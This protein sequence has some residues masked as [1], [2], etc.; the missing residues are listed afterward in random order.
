MTHRLV[1]WNYLRSEMLHRWRRTAL[2]IGGVALAATLVVMLDVLGRAF[3]D[4][5]TVPFRNLGA[6]LIVQRSATQS[7]VPKQMGIMLPFSAQPITSEELVRLAAEPGVAQAAGFVLLWNL[8]SGSFF[9][10]SGI[11][12]DANAPA[13]GPGRAREWLFKGRLP[14]AGER[15]IA[16]ERHYGAFYRL[17]PGNSI[18]IAGNAFKIVGVVETK[19]GSQIVAS[20][21]YMEIG[22]ARELA[23]LPPGLVKQVFLKVA[24]M[25]QTESIKQRIAK[26][27]PRASVASPGTMLQLF[28]GVSQTIGKFRTVGVAAG[29]AAALALSAMLILGALTERRRE[30]AVLRVIGWESSQVRRQIA[31]EMAVQGLLAG[32]LAIGLVAI[33]DNL[34]AHITIAMPASLPGENPADFAASG[35]HAANSALALPVSTTIWDWLLPAIVGALTCGGWGWWWSADATDKSLWA[36]VKAT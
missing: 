25:A 14:V 18:D 9:S 26:W 10:I 28:G 1:H 29:A 32:V 17:E 6:D 24:D 12:L 34:F 30:M 11:P 31:V 5:A 33:G 27:M 4:V 22:A 23:S 2:L 21:F 7:A 13:L 20:N 19:E 8:G 36:A 15:E 35:F 3:A 16:V